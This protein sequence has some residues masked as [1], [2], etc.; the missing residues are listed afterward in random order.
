MVSGRAFSVHRPGFMP[1][2]PLASVPS[3]RPVPL[4][5]RRAAF[6][7]SGHGD[8]G[9]HGHDRNDGYQGCNSAKGQADASQSLYVSHAA[10][11]PERFF[12]QTVRSRKSSLIRAIFLTQV[13]SWPVPGAARQA[14][15][16]PAAGARPGTA[17]L[18]VPR[19]RCRPR[20]RRDVRP[21]SK[22]QPSRRQVR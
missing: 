15:L 22:S 12:L 1:S 4:G 16:A 11:L 18:F 3:R 14:A 10:L 17:A 7:K 5:R 13:I 19:F 20:A 8:I 2:G 9:R 21:G 6:Q